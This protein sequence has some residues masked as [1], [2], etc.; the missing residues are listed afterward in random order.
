MS[1]SHSGPEQL[2]TRDSVEDFMTALAKLEARGSNLQQD[3]RRSSDNAIGAVERDVPR[4]VTSESLAARATTPEDILALLLTSR[5]LSPG[6]A[7]DI[8]ARSW[9]SSLLEAGIN[10]ASQI[11]R[12]EVTHEQLLAARNGAEDLVDS[13][14]NRRD[15]DS[16]EFVKLLSALTSRHDD[17]ADE[18]AA[19]GEEDI[20]DG[21]MNSLNARREFKRDMH[22]R[23]FLTSILSWGLHKLMSLS[24]RH[25][26]LTSDELAD[27]DYVDDFLNSRDSPRDELAGRDAVDEFINTIFS[28]PAAREPSPQ[29]ETHARGIPDSPKTVARDATDDFIKALL[30]SRDSSSEFTAD[31][32]LTLASLGSRALDELD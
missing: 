30:R 19:R 15:T 22:P 17:A 25:R 31:D 12:R 1:Q 10:L 16:N 11:L 32:L 6:S 3:A 2:T 5:D 8:E 27:R 14:I 24:I 7:P 29:Q 23:G 4:D 20:L 18:L 26:D 13:I 21:L 28:H 9:F